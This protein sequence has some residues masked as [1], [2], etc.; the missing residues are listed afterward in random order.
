MS[1]EDFEDFDNFCDRCNFSIDI[2]DIAII[3]IKKDI[4]LVLPNKNI[5]EYKCIRMNDYYKAIDYNNVVFT[6]HNIDL[7]KTILNDMKQIKNC[8][9]LCVNCHED[10]NIQTN[11]D[12]PKEYILDNNT[13]ES[14]SVS[15]S[16]SNSAS[17]D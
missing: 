4:S 16:D 3:L 15:E 5:N 9:A 7:D 11:E 17:N 14:N 1:L 10:I 2:N 12:I 6:I 13:S 8:L